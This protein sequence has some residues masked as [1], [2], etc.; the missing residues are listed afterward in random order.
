MENTISILRSVITLDEQTYRDFLTS[1][2]AMKRGFLIFLACFFIASLPIFG[3]RLIS[4]YRGFQP[5]VAVGIQEQFMTVFN[6][7]QLPEGFD[8]EFLRQF[9][10]N[11]QVGMDI[12]QQI[13]A[14]PMPLPRAISAFL[15]AL[16]AWISATIAPIGP[17]LGYGILVL[18]FAKLAGG[19]GILNHFF[20]LTALYAVPNLLGI[21]NFIPF[22]G[23]ALSLL[24]LIWGVV[25]Y[26][27]AV[28][29]SQEFTAGKAMLITLLPVLIVLLL[30]ACIGS[31]GLFSLVNLF[32]SGQ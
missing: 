2:D 27:R 21:F 12:G 24:G 1:K 25:V 29:I 22:V 8:E 28:Q 10:Q 26:V 20:G 15:Q 11:F 30:G 19:R 17:W 16:G 23:P 5:E 4:V 18:L 6:M 31:M 13:D 3:Q 14:L 32:R 9:Q 7:M